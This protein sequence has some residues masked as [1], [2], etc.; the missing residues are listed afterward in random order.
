MTAPLTK[1]KRLQ[2]TTAGKPVD[3]LP[4]ALWR[5]FFAEETSREGLVE[6]M[7][8]WQRE[9]DWDFLKIN[10]RASYHVEDWGNRY[11][12]SGKETIAPTLVQ[13]SVHQPDDFRHL[14][15]LD[16]TGAAGRRAPILADH[17]GAVGDL[18]KALG[19]DVP[20]L[21]TVFTPMSI[22]AELAGGPQ[23]LAALIQE[24]PRLVHVGL[25]T[26]TDTF[27][28]FAAGC[29]A[30]GADGLFLA[31]TH[32][33]TLANFTP[34]QYAEFGRPYDL[35][36]L[37]AARAA[38]LNLLHVCQR[39][40]M[41]GELADYPAAMLNW[42]TTDPTNPT[43][44]QMALGAAGKALVGGVDRKLFPDPAARE[45]LLAQVAEARKAMGDRPFVLGSTCTIDPASAPEMVRAFR[46]EAER[47]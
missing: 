16:P 46:E 11:T 25:R 26:I 6:A 27:A 14:D 28:G 15:R 19:P 21:M 2:R 12:F 5:H 37:T 42:D 4:V 38:P 43:L 24:N 20:L 45:T 9:Y 34:E 23:A 13:A 31:T 22:A 44:G 30:A 17:L 35:E 33:A 18:R 1:R 32:T 7:T 10:P 29:I 3:R 36:V 41:L 8:R 40:S 47:K 39:R